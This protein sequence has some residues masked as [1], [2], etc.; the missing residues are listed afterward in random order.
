[1]VPKGDSCQGGRPLLGDVSSPP[2]S[3]PYRNLS[4]LKWLE[5]PADFRYIVKVPIPSFPAL[6]RDLFHVLIFDYLDRYM[7]ASHWVTHLYSLSKI[8]PLP[9]RKNNSF[10]IQDQ[11]CHSLTK[12]LSSAQSNIRASQPGSLTLSDLASLAS[13]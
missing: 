3:H 9:S 8:F 12:T 4:G 13:L 2:F 6:P 1:M 7:I 5:G 11:P 10:Q